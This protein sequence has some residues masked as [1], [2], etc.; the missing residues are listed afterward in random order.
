[1]TYKAQITQFHSNDSKG[2]CFPSSSSGRQVEKL[3]GELNT[4]GAEKALLQEQ[5]ATLEASLVRA[6]RFRHAV[7]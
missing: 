7:G 3:R 5:K 2:Q 6:P 4:M 1:M